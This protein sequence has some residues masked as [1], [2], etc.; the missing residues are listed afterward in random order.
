MLRKL[1][2]ICTLGLVRWR[3]PRQRAAI[4]Q[5]RLADAQRR[6]LEQS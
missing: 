5:A 1:L 6:Q 4:A 3:T 2:S